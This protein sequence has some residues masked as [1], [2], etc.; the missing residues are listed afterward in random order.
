MPELELAS[1]R[2]VCLGRGQDVRHAAE[3]LWQLRKMLGRTQHELASASG[4]AQSD[5]SRVE[6]QRGDLRLSTLRRYVEGLGA[7][8][9]INA[10]VDGKRVRIW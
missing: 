5:L 8:L 9:E 3:A 6:R 4:I 7:A 1:G 10:V 2:F